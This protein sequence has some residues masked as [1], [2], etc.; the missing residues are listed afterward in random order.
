[1]AITEAAP[2]PEVH[3]HLAAVLEMLVPADLGKQMADRLVAEVPELAELSDPDFRAGLEFSCTDNLSAIW[4]LIGEAEGEAP[5]L[6]PPPGAAAWARELAHRGLPLSLLLRAYRLG[7]GYAEQRIAQ[8]TAELEMPAEIRWRIL[9]FFTQWTFE[10]IDAVCTQLV[11]D[12]E[13]ERARWVRGAAAAR[14]EYVQA[15]IERRPVETAAATGR[16]G[17]DVAR[18]HLGFI[19]WADATDA[20][21]RAGRLEHAAIELAAA[22]G[23]GP[24]LTIPV[25]ERV[26]WGWTSG[27]A[28][29]DDTAALAL[30][31][32]PGLR[33]AVGTISSGPV[34]MADSHADA[35]AV[36]RA[37]EFLG[38]RSG[39]VLGYR[40]VSLL[41]LLTAE[42]DRAVRF[43]ETELGGLA[44]DDDASR[45]LRATLRAY[46]EE[47]LSPARTGRRLAIHLNTVVYRVKQA[48][49][50]LGR[51]VETRRLELEAALRLAERLPALRDAAAR[52][53]AAH[54]RSRLH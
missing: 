21:Q 1:M 29:S 39:S 28:L 19:V 53:H 15:I 36:R 5:A 13:Q 51:S 41:G 44:A 50:I 11:E 8:V 20:A 48:E 43:V 27:D 4:Q 23:G 54:P 3:H 2:E 46:L 49:A 7:H 24:T 9:A 34:G 32:T 18:R 40:A 6:S 10:Y 25:G 22:L 31:M 42:P 14:A 35:I 38:Q 47:G 12:Y 33:A 37:S 16:L 45:R 30:S 26:V 17:Y 52:A